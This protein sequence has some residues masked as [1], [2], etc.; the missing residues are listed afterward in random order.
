[1]SGSEIAFL[2]IGGIGFILLLASFMFGEIFDFFDGDVDVGGADAASDGAS[3]VSTKVLF[4]GMV[5]FGTFGIV[6]SQYALPQA[7]I[8][9]IATGGMITVS[10][11]TFYLVLTP[12][13]KQQSNL[14][15]S[16]TSYEGLSATVSL[17]I[18]QE[19]N[20]MVTF[21]DRNGAFVRETAYLDDNMSALTKGT[22][23]VITT[24]N[25]GSVVVSLPSSVKEN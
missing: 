25:P 2:A 10:A 7:L 14:S 18:S 8:W 17:D 21:Y 5:G 22:Q 13:A 24:V 11:G 16:R 1:M 19:S 23:V 6:A 15:L 4:A 12:L 3:W 20:G 9:T